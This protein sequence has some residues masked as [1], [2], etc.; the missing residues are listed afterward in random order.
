MTAPFTQY[1]VLKDNYC[2]AYFG[3]NK[4]VLSKLLEAREYIEKELKKI[5]IFIACND[6][7]KTIVYGKRNIIL[8]SKMSDFKGKIGYFRNLERKEDLDLILAESKI[9]IPENFW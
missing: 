2:L 9:P 6:K 4:E 1:V 5:K 7:M 8:E 3:E